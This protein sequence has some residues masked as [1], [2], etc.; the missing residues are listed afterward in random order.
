MMEAVDILIGTS[1][2][3]EVQTIREAL[4]VLM[5]RVTVLSEPRS[6]RDYLQ[7]HGEWKD[8]RRTPELVIVD[9]ELMNGDDCWTLLGK[10]S[11]R[12]A[13]RRTT[14]A[15]LVEEPGKRDADRAYAAGVDW[16]MAK[17]LTVRAMAELVDELEDKAMAVV[18]VSRTGR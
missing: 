2:P 11:E 18:R 5:N 7:K 17:P 13:Y 6:V 9:M 10:L 1:D 15:A 16:L 4:R 3:Q 14:W 12:E 8:E